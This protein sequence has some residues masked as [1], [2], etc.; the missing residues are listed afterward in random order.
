MRSSIKNVMAAINYIEDHLSKKLDLEIVAAA[1]HYS[2]YHLHRMFTNTVGLTL[3]DYVQRRKLTEAAKLLIFSE[4]PIIEIAALAGYESQQAFTPV[5][6]AMYKQTPNQFRESDKFYPLQLRFI[7]K[8]NPTLTNMNTIDFTPNISYASNADIP[9]WMDLVRLVIDG[10]PCLVEHEYIGQLKQCIAEQRALIMKDEDT[11]VGVLV[12]C[13]E[14]GSIDFL[15]VHPQYRRKGVTKAFLNKLM[16]ECLPGETL[17]ITTYRE[18]D[19]A[20]TGYRDEYRQLGF[21]ES[22][23]LVEFGYPTQK[24]LLH[25]QIKEEVADRRNCTD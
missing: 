13:K 16:T 4:K 8:S 11:A 22:E 21:A 24:F 25:P 18:G 10:F 5:F 3:H 1:V 9:L 20:D 19:K 14:T 7:L 12:F 23:L 15:G 2:K 17:S 6:K